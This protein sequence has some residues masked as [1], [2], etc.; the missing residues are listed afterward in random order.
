MNLSSNL[1]ESA[2]LGATVVAASAAA[3]SA[4]LGGYLIFLIVA[5]A[6][7][8]A[9]KSVC[10]SQKTR[11][12]ILVPAHNEMLLIGRLIRSLQA[13]AYPR[14]LFDIFVVA[15]NCS[16]ATATIA[17]GVG[18]TV[19]ERFDHTQMGKGF[20]LRWL[21]QHL[22]SGYGEYDAYVVFDADSVVT[23][24]FLSAM[25]ARLERGASVVQGYY[26]VLNANDS[27]LAMLRFAALASL[28]YLRPLAREALG[29]SCGLKGNGMCF[30]ADVLHR[31]GWQWFT[32]AED[33][34]FHLALVREGIRVHFAWDARVDADMPVTFGQAVSQNA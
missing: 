9:R 27:P 25:D 12:A 8:P 33:V 28:H 21:L 19:L 1:L 5:A 11:F 23:E 32:L 6:F 2:A 26:S 17:R 15:D 34:E 29:L 22:S 16:D 10:G 3:L 13:Q 4:L 14:E 31:I 20:A 7:G 30:C 24:G 18:A